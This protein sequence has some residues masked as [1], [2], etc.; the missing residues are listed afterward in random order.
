[1]LFSEL[2]DVRPEPPMHDA[3]DNA[4]F[5]AGHVADGPVGRFIATLD[6]R[7]EHLNT[8][9]SQIH[10]LNYSEENCHLIQ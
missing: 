8:S 4:A 10:A 5:D 3:A 2:L 9:R 7:P 6:A 1:M